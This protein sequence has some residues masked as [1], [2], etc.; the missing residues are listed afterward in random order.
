MKVRTDAKRDE[1]LEV[2]RA[3]FLELGYERASMA[4]IATRVGG[5]K[6]T[7]YGYFPSKEALFLACIERLAEQYISPALEQLDASSDDVRT[8]L[9]RFGEQFLAFISTQE[10]VATYRMVISQAAHSEIGQAFFEAGPVQVDRAL[11]GYLSKVMNGGQLRKADAAVAATHFLALLAHGEM[12]RHYFLYEVPVL[13]RPQIKR[14]VE[15]AV[16]AF[17]TG[18]QP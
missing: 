16:D 5:S 11:A 4:E 9:R 8:A 17:M 10:A 13:T 2:A 15:R 7:L 6:A 18:Y 14:I 12:W 1:I 3:A